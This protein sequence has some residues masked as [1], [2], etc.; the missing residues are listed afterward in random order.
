MFEKVGVYPPAGLF[1]WGHLGLLVFFGA[2]AVLFVILTKNWTKD[3]MLTFFKVLSV[4]ILGL[5]I[6]KIIWNIVMYGITFET[7]DRFIPLYYCSI[8]IYAF[9]LLS[10]TKGTLSESSKAWMTYGGLIA[11]IS[12]LI[13][14]SSSLLEYPFFHFLSL[15]SIFFHV[16]LVLICYLLLKFE[17]YIPNK[18]DFAKY[19]YFSLVFMLSAFFLN[20][21]VGT[22]LMFLERPL[23]IPVFTLINDAS[24]LIFQVF[25]FLAQLFMPFIVTHGIFLFFTKFT[26][27]K[28]YKNSEK[29]EEISTSVR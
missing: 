20:K 15:H 28:I 22:N 12:F 29:S 23:A 5:E 6:F 8:F 24:P 3:R 26:N 2:L 14:P 17:F 4:V 11:G 16:A 7:L 27:L 10:W 9:L 25:I 19:T 13:Y 1:S 18:K 21:M